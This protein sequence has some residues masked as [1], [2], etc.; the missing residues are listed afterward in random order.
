MRNIL[1]LSFF[2]L[3]LCSCGGGEKYNFNKQQAAF[4][5]LFAD[6]E[7]E[8]Y[9]QNNDIQKKEL[10]K[11]LE[12]DLSNFIS[13]EKVFVNWQ[14]QIKDI[15]TTS[16]GNSTAVKFTISYRPDEH[17]EVSFYC[18]HVVATSN[19]ESDPIYNKVK[20]LPNHSLV[21]FDGIIRT[22][23]N[24]NVVYWQ[25]NLSDASDIIF[26]DYDFLIFDISAESHGDSLSENLQEVLKHHI[27]MISLLRQNYNGDISEEKMNG[28]MEKIKPL[29][30]SAKAKLTPS[31][32]EYMERYIQAMAINFLCGD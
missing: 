29:F 2:A 6:S 12:G 1:L 30:E 28:E 10:L 20:Q 3:M 31:E 16:L 26:P 18:T 4:D 23:K 15:K 5:K 21:Y 9:K 14:G 8:L 32:V 25:H 24:D 11:K 17:R 22:D 7:A 19:L 13:K 27:Q